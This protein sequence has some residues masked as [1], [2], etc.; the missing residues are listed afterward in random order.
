MPSNVIP[1]S[2][3][4]PLLEAIDELPTAIEADLETGSHAGNNAEAIAFAHQYPFL[5]EQLKTIAE[6]SN[7]VHDYYGNKLESVTSACHTGE[8]GG[9]K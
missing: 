3:V 9:S 8:S 6:L 2:V 7:K 5:M 1:C 4:A